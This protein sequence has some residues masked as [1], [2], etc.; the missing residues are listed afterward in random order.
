M[1]NLSESA[2]KLTPAQER[3]VAQ[4]DPNEMPRYFRELAVQQGLATRDAFSP[5]ILIP[6][7]QE[8][9]VREGQA[10]RATPQTFT[11]EEEIGGIRMKFEASSELELDK[12]IG[13][14]HQVA[15]VLRDESAKEELPAVDPRIQYTL[16]ENQFRCGAI[17]ADEFLRATHQDPESV[18]QKEAAFTRDWK[19]ASAAWLNSEAGSDWPGG[20]NNVQ[21]MGLVLQQLDLVDSADKQTALSQA[22]A[23][24]RRRGLI[25]PGA[26]SAGNA[27]SSART[28]EEVKNAA[29]RVSG[30]PEGW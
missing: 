10:P 6:T 3:E 28:F 9:T 23:E 16:L 20:E 29:H 4:M 26:A 19:D 22:Y 24:M 30:L 21:L 13:E 27:F 25:F 1:S 12:R 5:D 17:S 18:A 8:P 11:R 2:I 14:A 15:H 7:V